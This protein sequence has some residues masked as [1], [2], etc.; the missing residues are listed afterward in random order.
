[1]KKKNTIVKFYAER[2]NGKNETIERKQIG[3][4]R[5]C[6][7]NNKGYILSPLKYNQ[8]KRAL[9]EAFP[10]KRKGVYICLVDEAGRK[11]TF[12]GYPTQY[13]VWFE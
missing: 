5:V 4:A 8:L 2:R 10:E 12:G 11:D 1:M 3:S 7:L 9:F 13:G 6:I